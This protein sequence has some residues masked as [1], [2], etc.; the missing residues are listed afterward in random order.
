MRYGPREPWVLERRRPATAPGAR[1]ALLGPSGAGKTTLAQLLVRFR[2][3]DAGQR[4][5]SAASTCAEL[6][7]DDLRRAVVLGAQDAHLFN[8]TLRENILLARREAGED[9]IWAA[10]DDAGAG[11]WVARAPDTAS[12]RSSAR[13]AALVSGGQRQRI[14]LARALLA[15]ARF[16]IL[17][18]PTAHLDARHGAAGDRRHRRGRRRARGA[19]HHAQ[20]GRARPLRRGARAA[21]R[22]RAAVALVG[23]EGDRRTLSLVVV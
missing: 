17:D 16:L 19:R 21:R 6:T 2:D 5:A 9:E 18:E 1:V 10:L 14:A 4:H 8:T 20:R 13:A 11:D 12:T 22:A 3:P 15:D 7:Q 23:A